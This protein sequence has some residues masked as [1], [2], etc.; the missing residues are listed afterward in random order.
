[1]IL[2]S[3]KTSKLKKYILLIASVLIVTTTTKAQV[4]TN[5]DLLG[6]RNVITTAAPFLLIS[7]DSRAAGMGDIGVATSADANSIHWNPAKLAFVEKQAGISLSAAPWLRTL[8]PDVWFYY[9]SGYTK[10]GNNDRSAIGASLRYFSLGDIQ[11][12]DELGNPLGNYEP[13]EFAFDANY[14]T[15]LSDNFSVGVALRFIFSDLARGQVGNSGTEIKAGIAGAGDLAAFYTNDVEIGG[16]EFDFNVGLNVSNIGNKISYTNNGQA[17]FIPTNLKLGTFWN[18]QIDEHNEIGIGI[19]FNKLLVPTPQYIY[20]ST[21][22]IIGRNLSTDPVLVGMGKSFSDAPGGFREEMNE[23]NI[24]IGAE[25]WYDDQFALRVGF[26]HEDST[27]GARQYFTFGAGLKYNVFQ[28]DAAYLQP[29][30]RRHPLQNTIRF[31]LL[32]D[33]DAF[34]KQNEE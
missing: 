6:Q 5:S 4:N 27:K 20:D 2:L 32:F 16:R 8:I 21:G 23:V 13:K 11:F 1:M 26:F 24:S 31:S 3:P 25:Y 12:T 7:P 28:I 18:T 14:A 17:D 33:I 9:L 29:I 10:L 30:A 22:N 19:D 34:R 15:K